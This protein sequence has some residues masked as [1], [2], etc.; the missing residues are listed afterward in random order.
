ML[1]CTHQ[2]QQRIDVVI[3]GSVGPPFAAARALVNDLIALAVSNHADRRHRRTAPARSIAGT[4]VIHME[5]PQTSRAVVAIAAIQHRIDDCSAANAREAGVLEFSCQIPSPTMH[6]AVVGNGFGLLLPPS[7]VSPRCSFCRTAR[8]TGRRRRLPGLSRK[9][10]IHLASFGGAITFDSGFIR[11]C[12]I[13][14]S[15]PRPVLCLCRPL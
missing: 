5:R 10:S 7:R 15:G 3:G 12:F 8:R 13:S 4:Y 2:A 11:A 1:L 6:N 9:R 14:E